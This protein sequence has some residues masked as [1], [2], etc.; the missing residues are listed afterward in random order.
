MPLVAGEKLGRCELAPLP[1]M[2]HRTRPDLFVLL[3]VTL[4]APS[5]AQKP[6]VWRDPS[7]HKVQFA[8]VDEKVQL[9]VL[10]WGGRGLPIVL[11]AGLGNTAHVFDD[12]AP[13]LTT[14][15][16]VYGIT[17]RGYGA[18]GAPASGYTADR[19]GDDVLAVLDSLQLSKPVLVGHSMG[20]EEL[21]SVGSRHPSRVAGLVYLDA[22]YSYAFDAG[23][24][25]TLEE[26]AK[27]A[28]QEPS[29]GPADLVSFSALQAWFGRV[30][31]ITF[32][33]AEFRQTTES[34]PDGHVGKLRTQPS[35]QQAIMAGTQKYT[36][37][38]VPALAI[39]A[40]PHDQGPWMEQNNDPAVKAYAV[41]V[42]A[43]VEDQVNA[44]ETGVPTARI[45]RLPH[46]NHYVFLSNE[47]DVL[48]EM[49]A[50]LARLK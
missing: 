46:A 20:G 22:G 24:G 1:G 32:P 50:F 25:V 29:P 40:L 48:R 9:E 27:G 13:K 2:L 23:K 31:G 43:I 11:L 42:D 45:I 28:P 38:P 10:D 14:D 47:A 8:T 15:Y 18:S 37:I 7:S 26:I 36:N 17:R 12:F 39:F 44:F 34:S 30:R 49:R 3:I 21:S 41:R 19:L 35:V 16:H 4:L 6:A 33:V 5:C